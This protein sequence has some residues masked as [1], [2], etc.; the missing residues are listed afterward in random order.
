MAMLTPTWNAPANIGA[1]S[2]TRTGG[3]SVAPFASLNLG[4]HVGDDEQ[5]VLANRDHLA[6]YLPQPPVWLN[7][8]HS[9]DVVVVDA[10]FTAEL[11][12]ADALYTQLQNRPLAIMT[13]DCLPV[14]LTSTCGT[15]VAAIHGGWRGLNL[16]I[17]ANT[18]AHFNAPA[19]QVI[20]WLGP[21][22]GAQKFEVGA[23][24]KMAF[25]EQS[26]THA[27]AFTV[28]SNGKYLADIYAIARHQL[29]QLGVKH[30][31]GGEYC[32]VSQ[33]EQF[34]SYRRDGQTGRMASLI[35]RK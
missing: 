22:I 3:S 13:A 18:L 26:L 5:A 24:V 21:A 12:N 31:S 2:T 8:V 34:F 30:I 7:Q 20:A 14:L 4:L 19:E 27:A 9:A 10:R 16:G 15:E 29:N 28:L 23:E 6:Q 32:T 11:I 33:P 25:C 1:L 17:I 35:W